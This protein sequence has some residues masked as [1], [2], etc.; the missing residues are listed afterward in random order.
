MM[1]PIEFKELTKQLVGCEALNSVGFSLG[2]IISCIPESIEAGD[3]KVVV[4]TDRGNRQHLKA[5]VALYDGFVLS[6]SGYSSWSILIDDKKDSCRKCTS[7][8]KDDKICGLYDPRRR[9]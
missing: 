9:K 8:C 7:K 3:Y 6:F 5:S 2:S 1:D 4:E